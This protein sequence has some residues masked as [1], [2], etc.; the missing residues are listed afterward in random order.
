VS[1]RKADTLRGCKVLTWSKTGGGHKLDQE[2]RN[3]AAS[4][5][6]LIFRT[7]LEVV[8]M[9]QA[10]SDGGDWED[11]G[12]TLERLRRLERA[13]SQALE[14]LLWQGKV[15]EAAVLRREHVAT[16]KALLMRRVKQFGSRRLVAS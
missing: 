5:R 16:V 4:P 7:T 15:A 6:F 8:A 12:A 13:T 1:F 14:R 10:V 11:L 3:G 9:R 2:Q